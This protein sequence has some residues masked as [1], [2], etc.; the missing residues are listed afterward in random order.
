MDMAV[1]MDGAMAAAAGTITD[2]AEVVATT[3]VGDRH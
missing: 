3:M 2:G 1:V